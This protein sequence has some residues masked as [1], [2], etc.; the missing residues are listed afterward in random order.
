M[1]NI[2]SVSRSGKIIGIK[3][4]KFQFN[5]KV[6]KKAYIVFFQAVITACA[7]ESLLYLKCMLLET[8]RQNSLSCPLWSNCL[9]DVSDDT[10]SFLNEDFVS[11]IFDEEEDGV[12]VFGLKSSLNLGDSDSTE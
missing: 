3:T 12:L 1:Q 5:R 11:W 4:D 2:G 9:I 6:L 10:S 8:K 7:L